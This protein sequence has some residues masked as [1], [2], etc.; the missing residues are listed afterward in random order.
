M[1]GRS[2]AARDGLR[3]AYGTLT[4]IPVPPPVRVD[5]D[6]ARWAMSLGWLLIAP[7]T[8]MIGGVGWALALTG[9]PPLA[10]G[11]LVVGMTQAATRFIHA[12]GLADTADGLGASWDRGRA[13]EVMRQGDVGPIGA[14]TLVVVL[15]VQA[16]GLGE[17]AAR[18]AG[19]LVVGAAIGV[20]R[21][22]LALGTTRGVP[23][24]RSEGLGAAVAGSVPIPLL[25]LALLAAGGALG[26]ATAASGQGWLP[27]VVSFGVAIPAT[28][29]FLAWVVRR[30]GGITGDV[31]GALVEVAAMITVV[32]L[33]VFG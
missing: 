4:R 10:V 22:A 8:L 15:G 6:A 20:P 31:L 18:P 25:G 29:L 3:L 12:D 7:M 9:I 23:S 24:A 26:A 11:L 17:L 19:W 2:G 30:L 28:A 32:V 33:I 14:T 1:G 5:A 16:A 13:L 27:G 21:V